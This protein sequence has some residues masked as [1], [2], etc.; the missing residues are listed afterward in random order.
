MKKPKPETRTA[1][2]FHKCIRYIEDKYNV[3]T[4]DWYRK[5]ERKDKDFKVTDRPYRNFWHFLLEH[6]VVGKESEF[7]LP[8]KNT[9]SGDYHDLWLC[10]KDREW[11]L[12]IVKLIDKEFGEHCDE[13][14]FLN[15]WG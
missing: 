10:D 15:F 6:W 14:G 11:A 13:N 8:I 7:T 1:L 3:E 9:E 2:N 4:S 12:E 5:Y